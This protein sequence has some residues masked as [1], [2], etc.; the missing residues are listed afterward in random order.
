VNV[1][2]RPY[3]LQIL[4]LIPPGSLLEPVWNYTSPQGFYYSGGP[5]ADRERMKQGLE[6]LVERGDAERVFFDRLTLC[7]NC[8]NHALNVRE[9]CPSC[10]SAHLEP[11]TAIFHFRCGFVGPESAFGMEPGGLRCPKCRRL[12]KDLGTDYDSPGTFFE[13]RSCT[14]QFQTAHIGGRCLACGCR[15]D[16][17]AMQNVQ[18]LDVFAY[19]ITEKGRAALGI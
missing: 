18:Q 13:C 10:G 6:E 3:L 12:L 14:A 4:A 15:F 11:F 16:Q 1:E 9:I 17:T 7:P 5:E 8:E 2:D 19:R